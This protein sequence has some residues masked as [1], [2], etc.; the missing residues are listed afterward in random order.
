ME[1]RP[2][3]PPGCWLCL[4]N[5]TPT[6][7][8]VGRPHIASLSFFFFQYSILRRSSTILRDPCGCHALCYIVLQQ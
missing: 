4:S 2:F 3:W 7:S 6:A 8:F 1:P 5:L